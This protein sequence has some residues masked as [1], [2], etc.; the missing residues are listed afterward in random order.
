V[1]GITLYGTGGAVEDRLGVFAFNLAGL[2]HQLVAAVLSYEW[3]IAIRSGCFCA[4][5]YMQHLLGIDD[6][7]SAR[8]REE[9]ARGDRSRLPGAVRASFGLGTST[10]EVDALV[11]ALSAIAAGD[12]RAD[13]RVDPATGEYAPEGAGADAFAGLLSGKPEL[14]A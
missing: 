2:P 7:W 14:H 8:A 12:F 9:I 13:Y 10:A 5:P 11:A 1:P 3:G 6:D 4:H